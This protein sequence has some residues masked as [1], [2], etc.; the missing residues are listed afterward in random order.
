M[1]TIVRYLSNRSPRVRG[2]AADALIHIGDV[3]DPHVGPI[4]LQ[5]IE[6]KERREGMH[7]TLALALAAVRYRPAIPVLIRSL[8]SKNEVV[9]RCAAFALS[10]LGAT[11]A[12]GALRK[13]IEQ[14]DDLSTR[15]Q[16]VRYLEQLLG[17]ST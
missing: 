4:L 6:G 5:R 16:L 1:P 14:E 2:E 13:A 15:I 12:I 11:E 8:S 10:D 7:S 17:A 9:R 3:G